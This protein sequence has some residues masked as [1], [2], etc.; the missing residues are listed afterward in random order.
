MMACGCSAVGGIMMVMSAV[1]GHM[2]LGGAMVIDG[3][4]AMDGSMSLDGAMEIN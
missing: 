1:D 2:T 3:G 4:I